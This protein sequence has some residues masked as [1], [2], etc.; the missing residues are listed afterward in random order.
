[1]N[2]I[3]PVDW[4]A[5]QRRMDQ[6]PRSSA[7]RQAGRWA[8]SSVERHL[9]QDWLAKHAKRGLPLPAEFT[10]AGSDVEALSHLLDLALR[11]ELLRDVAGAGQVRNALRTDLRAEARRH[12][13]VQLEV[14]ALAQRAGL[15]VRL[16]RKAVGTGRPSD[17]VFGS[18][19]SEVAAEVR[20]VLPDQLATEGAL[21]DRE[22]S[23]KLNELALIH[24]VVF[25]GQLTV[26]LNE[27]Q[28]ARW[29]AQ[30]EA[31]AE[32]VAQTGSPET[33]VWDGETVTVLLMASAEEASFTGPVTRARGWMRTRGILIDKAPQ[34][35]AQGGGWLRVDSLDGLF[36]ASDWAQKSLA[37]RTSDMEV[38]IREAV[39]PY[40]Y[41]YG[42]VLTSGLC[43][44]PELIGC[45]SRAAR[46]SY[47]FER[48]LP[49]GRGRA[50]FITPLREEAGPGLEEWRELY[51]GEAAWLDWAL[52][53]VGLPEV[54][55]ITA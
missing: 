33:V 49:M 23:Q 29:F 21:Y 31:A 9:G 44:A 48:S 5:L 11:L 52:A 27:I 7:W 54:A 53:R 35:E 2:A 12:A 26:R 3:G 1:M 15:H 55:E 17:V 13:L 30:L 46:G 38:Y 39:L 8:L 6:G 51:D 45:S 42:V 28:R 34:L 32:S 14:A 47:G 50:T 19:G 18:M 20:L 4:P 25:D 43:W 41:V 16:E 37:E 10:R 22:I 36:W 24:G 40:A